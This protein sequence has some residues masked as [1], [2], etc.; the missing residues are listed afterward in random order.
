MV[1]V[2]S[3]KIVICVTEVLRRM[4]GIGRKTVLSERPLMP[5]PERQFRISR[6]TTGTIGKALLKSR[7]D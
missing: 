3:G 6:D 4:I 1:R 5:D 2:P 7:K